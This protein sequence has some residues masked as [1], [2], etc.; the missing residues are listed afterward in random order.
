[1]IKSRRV[2]WAGH[3]ARIGEGRG[4]YVVL[5]GNLRKR[6]HLVDQGVDGRVILR[7][8]FCK[9]DVGVWTG[10]SWLWIETGGENL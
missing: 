5:V 8:I 7:R 6:D 9:W 10:L 1:V 4:V 3:V 2:R